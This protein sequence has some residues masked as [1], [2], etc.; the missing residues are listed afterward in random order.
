MGDLQS[1]SN[2]KRI[3]AAHAIVGFPIPN[4]QDATASVNAKIV[5][6][7]NPGNMKWSKMNARNTVIM[8]QRTAVGKYIRN[9]GVDP[10]WPFH[11]GVDETGGPACQLCVCVP[12]VSRYA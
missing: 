10:G 5:N 4:A 11:Y 8:K 12:I 1:N 3:E 2:Y 7:R 6:C 9:D